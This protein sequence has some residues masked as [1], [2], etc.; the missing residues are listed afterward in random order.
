MIQHIMRESGK[1][2]TAMTAL[3]DSSSFQTLLLPGLVHEWASKLTEHST[4]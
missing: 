4:A 3:A 1:I 2:T